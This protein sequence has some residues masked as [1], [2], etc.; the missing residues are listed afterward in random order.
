MLIRIISALVLL[1][2]LAIPGVQNAIEIG[3]RHRFSF[4]LLF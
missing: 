4:M 3:I 1:M 2:L